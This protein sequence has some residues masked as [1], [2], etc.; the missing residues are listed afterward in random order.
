MSP[1]ALLHA[2]LQNL[3]AGTNR[4]GKYGSFLES[5]GDGLFQIDVFA[6]RQGVDGHANV[7]VIRRCD[8]YGIDVGGEHL[9]I[10]QVSSRDPVRPLLDGIAPRPVDIA[11]CHNLV[12]AEFVGSI[13]QVPHTPA[14]S[15][16]S[17]ANRVIGARHSG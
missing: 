11:H 13:Q 9:T 7:P 15:D 8:E 2:A 1:T 5:V 4:A 12:R 14:C 6:G 17:E 10:I 16:D 3:L